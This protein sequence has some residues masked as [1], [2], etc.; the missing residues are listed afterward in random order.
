MPQEI[1]LKGPW[2]KTAAWA[3]LTPGGALELELYDYSEEAARWMGNDVAWIWRVAPGDLPAARAAIAQQAPFALTGG[4]QLLAAL[5]A[6]FPH[7]HAVRDWLRHC[8]VPLEEKFDSW[9]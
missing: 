9:A 2:E 5:A 8:G 6:R 4:D 1:R 7:V 3:R